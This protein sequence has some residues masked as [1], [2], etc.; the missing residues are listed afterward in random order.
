M[1]LEEKKAEVIFKALEHTE[2]DFV[3]LG[4]QEF[5]F[6]VPVLGDLTRQSA[7][8]L[9]CANVKNI[10]RAS[11]HIVPYLL[12]K[13]GM[14]QV[15]IASVMD[16]RL[17]KLPGGG[18]VLNDPVDAL[19][20]IQKAV[21]HDLFIVVCH[22]DTATAEKW[23]GQVSGI[24]LAILGH[25]PGV[26]QRKMEINGKRAVFNNARGQFVSHV[27]LVPQD[28]RYAFCVPHNIKLQVK[29]VS[30]D[31]AIA[32]L[33]EEYEVWSRK[34]HY[35]KSKNQPLTALPS[36]LENTYVGKDRCIECHEETAISWAK[37]AHARALDS[38]KRKGKEY[39][40]Q[41]LPCHV[42][43]MKEE[44]TAGGFMSI[45]L[46]PHMANVQCEQCHGPARLHAQDPDNAFAQLP[47]EKTC[48][49]CHTKDTDP[50]FSYQKK[51]KT[52]VH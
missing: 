52:G 31:H 48:L 17:L 50:N 19:I 39:N 41:C 15:L 51:R 47:G 6:G 9:G 29:T 21:G 24:D 2:V 45:S 40:P 27:D 32:K 22:A 46:T 43:G 14:K 12:L 28:G 1:E 34:Y 30:E 35:E 16:P 20:D 5:I 37:T 11:Q 42:T 4:E 10:R 7:I 23:L 13:K 38:L 26:S 44:S 33:I 25:Q 36:R 8:R 3:A 18:I 49:N